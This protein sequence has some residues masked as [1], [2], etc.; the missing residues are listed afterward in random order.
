MS[1]L[2]HILS[3]PTSTKRIIYMKRSSV[4]EYIDSLYILNAIHIHE[5][6]GAMPADQGPG[7]CVGFL[8]VL[9]CPTTV[10]RL[11]T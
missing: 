8:R 1:P 2:T 5:G 4:A 3:T 10:Q 11:A 6:S 9:W 7:A